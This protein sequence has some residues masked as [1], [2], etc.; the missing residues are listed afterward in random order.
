VSVLDF[1]FIASGLTAL[2]TL[3]F[4]AFAWSN[5]L[6]SLP[7]N[8]IFPIRSV[9]FFVGGVAIAMCTAFISQSL[10][11]DDV[12]DALRSCSPSNSTILI[13]GREVSNPGET[14]DTLKQLH[15]VLAHHSSPTKTFSIDI[16]GPKHLMLALSRDSGNPREYW[17]FY[18]KYWITR[19]N[20]IGRVITPVFDRY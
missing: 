20:E 7:Q 17:V 15:H 6:G 1:V 12:L 11:Q 5:Y 10:T 2:I 18:P 14:L 19:H 3:P 13:N 9:A 16:N 8:R 4:L